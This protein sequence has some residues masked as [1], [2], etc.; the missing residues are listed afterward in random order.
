MNRTGRT[1]AAAI[2]CAAL[3]LPGVGG[4]VLGLHHGHSAHHHHEPPLHDAEALDLIVHGHHHE[5][6][7]PAHQHRFALGKQAPAT[8]KP[9]I[10][11]DAPALLPCAAVAAR[12]AAG[13]RTTPGGAAHAPPPGTTVSPV[14][15]I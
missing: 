14:L 1:S 10:L 9:S 2:L 11:L 3:V 6:G 7:A 4:V 12:L 8:T 13:S 15:R 5:P